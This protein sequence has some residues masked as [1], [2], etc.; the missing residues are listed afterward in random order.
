MSFTDYLNDNKVPALVCFTGSLLFSALLWLFGL[1]TGEITLLWICFIC[2]A[3]GSLL[4]GYFHKRKRILYLKS[5]MA[6]LDQ[7]YLFA[8]VTDSPESELEK[9]YFQLMKT[10]LKAMTDEVSASRRLNSEY[11]DFVEQWIHEMK[12]PVTGIR[13]LCENHK[14]VSSGSDG[15]PGILP[16]DTVRKIMTQTEIISQ[17]VERVLFYARLGSVEKDYLITE[18]S[19]KACA[20]EALA[21]NRQ[22]LIQ[23][24][25]CVHT[26]KIPDTVYS[27][28]KWLT[29]IL[30]QILINSV[31]YQGIHPPVIELISKD[32][33]NYV[34]LSVTDNGIGIKESELSRVFDKGFV[35][36]NG[37]AGS[38]ATGIGLYLCRQLCDR[39]GIGIDIESEAG[40][41]TTVHLHF[42]K[43][44]CQISFQKSY[45]SVR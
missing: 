10:A 27:D 9:I 3:G 7:K 18:V 24:N 31:K 1:G 20:L 33:G 38:H 28:S 8:E 16:T 11:R 23:N 42:P 41:Y 25:T 32:H 13:L 4:T 44:D 29:F 14:T 19:L 2:T 30:S 21:R 35:G 6:S 37:R 26:E 5:V 36:S 39:L 43:N 17:N 12:V 45:N 34:T 40:Q 15:N 22:F